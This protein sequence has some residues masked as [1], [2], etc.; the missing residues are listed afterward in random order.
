MRRRPSRGSVNTLVMIDMATGLSIDPPTAWII[1]AAIS[2]P[3]VGATLHSS[4][5]RTNMSSPAWNVR[6]LPKRSAVEP[7]SSSRLAI[8]TV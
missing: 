3:R 5:P 1:L 7:A 8:T 6:R 2:Q 4:E